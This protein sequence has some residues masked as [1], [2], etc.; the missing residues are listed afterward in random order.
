MPSKHQNI[1]FSVEHEDLNLLL[2]LDVKI[3]HKMINLSLVFKK[4]SEF[5]EVF[6]HY[7]SFIT[8]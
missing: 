4:K 8:K 6:T 7:E 2:F 3:Y 1:N 5:G